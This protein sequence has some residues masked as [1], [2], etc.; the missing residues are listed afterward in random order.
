MATFDLGTFPGL[1]GCGCGAGC[2]CTGGCPTG[3]HCTTADG[4]DFTCAEDC[5]TAGCP[6]G[7]TCGADGF[8]YPNVC[9][10]DSDCPPHRPYCLDGNCV[11][12]KLDS[13]CPAEWACDAGGNCT[14][15]AGRCDPACDEGEI[16][17]PCEPAP[18]CAPCDNAS[19]YAALGGPYNAGW[20]FDCNG[21]VDLV[22][23]SI[24]RSVCGG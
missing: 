3:Y 17:N 5:A 19:F 4:E 14:P 2:P 8:C 9:V 22:D 13:H 10:N 23:W 24:Y 16:C 21:N 18:G 6:P 12:C 7:Y 1:T 15:P 11:E 20:D